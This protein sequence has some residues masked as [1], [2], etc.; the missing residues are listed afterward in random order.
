MLRMQGTSLRNHLKIP[1]YPNCKTFIFAGPV[2]IFIE[3]MGLPDLA[4]AYATADFPLFNLY[5]G[6]D[7]RRNWAN[8]SH[9]D[10]L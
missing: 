5:F 1:L 3:R 10:V 7:S 9:V 6:N 2:N 8:G 4:V